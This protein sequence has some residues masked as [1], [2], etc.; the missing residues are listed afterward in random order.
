[1]K[2]LGSISRRMLTLPGARLSATASYAHGD[3]EH[4]AACGVR[5]EKLGRSLRELVQHRGE[6]RRDV[7]ARERIDTT[8]T[9]R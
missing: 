9:G 7:A 3:D 2:A 4:S 6:L 5:T 8:E 1:L